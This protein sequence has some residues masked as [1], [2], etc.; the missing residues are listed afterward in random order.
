MSKKS[1]TLAEIASLT[2]VALRALEASQQAQI[3][4]RQAQDEGWE[5]DDPRWEDVFATAHQARSQALG[6]L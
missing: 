1:E 5:D 6:R 4:V 2:S 3:A